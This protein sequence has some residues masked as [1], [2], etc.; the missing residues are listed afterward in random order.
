M[1]ICRVQHDK[2]NPYLTINT[3]IAQD[4]R[5]SWKAKGIW[6]YAYSRKDDWTFYMN[7]LLKRSTDGIDSLRAGIKELENCG[8]L[9]RQIKQCEV[10]GQARGHEWI[11][12]ET[13][14]TEEEIKIIITEMGVFRK[15]GNPDDGEPLPLTNKES[16]KVNKKQQQELPAAVFPCLSDLKHNISEE[17]K[18][19]I[20]RTYLEAHVEHAVQA[21]NNKPAEDIT[22]PG[23]LLETFC[24][25]SRD[26]N[27]REPKIH[28]TAAAAKQTNLEYLEKNK[29]L[30]G[31]KSGEWDINVG[32]DYIQ[33]NLGQR[34][35]TCSVNEKDFIEKVQQMDKN[36]RNTHKIQRSLC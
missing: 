12:F 7:D 29:H 4:P 17:H 21:F 27:G 14:K 15:T 30:H 31:T 13:P 22:N 10:T 9:H 28:K 20:S 23:G 33:F 26:T 18:R 16:S 1:T 35:E 19:R 8:Y 34:Q 32:T 24:Q 3:S 6:L 25:Q 5:I 11:F 36:C 2:N